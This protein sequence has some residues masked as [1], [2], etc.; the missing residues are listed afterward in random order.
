MPVYI[1]L[2]SHRYPHDL[3]VL[4]SGLY[5]IEFAGLSQLYAV[6]GVQ[7]VRLTLKLKCADQLMVKTASHIIITR[8]L[9]LLV[10]CWN[11]HVSTTPYNCMTK[12][13]LK[14]DEKIMPFF[15]PVGKRENEIERERGTK[16]EREGSEWVSDRVCEWASERV[17]EWVSECVSEGGREGGS[18]DVLI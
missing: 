4:Y 5:L 13:L 10:S 1:P 2:L 15:Q 17:S 9:K 3:T 7:K 6:T 18:C 14:R 8:D 11:G 16:R 12:Y